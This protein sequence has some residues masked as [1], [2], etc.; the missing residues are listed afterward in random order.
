MRVRI[1]LRAGEGMPR[2]RSNTSAYVSI[3]QHTRQHTSAYV[4]IRVS[5]LP[6]G[7]GMSRKKKKKKVDALLLHVSAY[8]SACCYMCPHTCP[9]TTTCGRRDVKKESGRH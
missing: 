4:S 1:L 3:R 8:V 2:V 6:A 7:E 9:H 5:I